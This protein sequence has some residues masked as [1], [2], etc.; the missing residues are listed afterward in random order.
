MPSF[1]AECF[2]VLKQACVESRNIQAGLRE[3]LRSVTSQLVSLQLVIGQVLQCQEQAKGSKT[4]VLD[5]TFPKL[6]ILFGGSP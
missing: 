3:K 2:K 1:K 4:G 5:E 6:G